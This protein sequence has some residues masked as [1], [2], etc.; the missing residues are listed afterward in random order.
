MRILCKS[1]WK[2]MH[3]VSNRQRNNDDYITS[4]AEVTKQEGQHPRT[5]QRVANF[6]LLANQSAERR[7]VT[8]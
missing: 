2:F 6:R 7:L 8:Q 5:G 3:K 4:L 1:V